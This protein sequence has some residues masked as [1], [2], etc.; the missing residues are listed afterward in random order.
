MRVDFTDLERFLIW[1]SDVDD[2]D[3]PGSAPPS[4]TEGYLLALQQLNDPEFRKRGWNNDFQHSSISSDL[5]YF[6]DD[7]KYDSLSNPAGAGWLQQIWLGGSTATGSSVL[8]GDIREVEQGYNTAYYLGNR[9][10]L[11]NR[12][13]VLVTNEQM[14]CR[15]TPGG[16]G[17]GTGTRIGPS[18]L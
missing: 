13:S 5:A 10:F 8:S 3:N 16:S 18:R 4:G 1:L 9:Y 2:L 11:R 14:L 7:Y 6:S 15:W 17:S 12:Y